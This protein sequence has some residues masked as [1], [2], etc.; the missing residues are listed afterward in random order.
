[1]KV[2]VIDGLDNTGKTTVINYLKEVYKDYKIQQFYCPGPINETTKEGK[3]FHQH[4]MYMDML[5]NILE[6]NNTGEYD[7]VIY[8]R[9]W[10]SEYV[11]GQI[12]RERPEDYIRYDNRHIEKIL[13]ETIGFDNVYLIMLMS[14]NIDFLIKYED[15]KSLSKVKEDLLNK[16]IELFKRGFSLSSIK[17]KLMLY[18][19]N[20]EEFKPREEIKDTIYNFINT[21]IPKNLD[22]AIK[23]LD[24]ELPEDTKE[25]LLENGALS[26]HHSLGRW[27]RN[28]W[29][30]WNDES[31]LKD[32]ISKLGYEHPDDI[33]NY[34]IEKYIEYLKNKDQF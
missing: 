28:K 18:V 11:Y 14:D 25:F 27:I 12:Y 31:E 20:G 5:E 2:F 29:G 26:V 3:W 19:N 8:D 34:I 24:K 9:G 10:F 32:N 22:E 15:G 7:I 23:E 1:M 30:L 13:K 16:E 33:S 21:K 17:N 4:R 6:Y